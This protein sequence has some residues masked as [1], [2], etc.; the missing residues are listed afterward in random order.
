MTKILTTTLV[1]LL[2]TS[3][4]LSSSGWAMDPTMPDTKTPIKHVII[5]FQENISYDHYFGVYPNAPGFTAKSGT[6]TSDNYVAHPG[7]LTA[8]GNP[9][10]FPAFLLS[11]SVTCDMDHDYLPEQ[12]AYDGGLADKFVQFTSDSGAGCNPNGSTVMGYYDGQNATAQ[13]NI[14][15]N[16]AMSDSSFDT[17]FGPSTPGAVDLISGQTFGASEDAVAGGAAISDDD[18]LYDDCH[19]ASETWLSMSGKNIGDVLNEKG[20]TWGWF[21]GGFAP[22]TPYNP[23]T[24]AP[25][26]CNV[27]TATILT[28]S[29]TAYSAHHEPFEYYNST[30]NP[31]HLPPSTLAEIGYTDQANHQYD[32]SDFWAAISGAG[33]SQ[34]PQVSFIKAPKGDDGHASYSDPVDEGH[35]LANLT[36]TI[37]NSPYWSNTAV[38]VLWDDSDGWYDHVYPPIVN[39]SNDPVNDYAPTC[40]S[41]NTHDLGLGDA[42]DRCGYGARLPFLVISPYAKS[43]YISHTV[44]DQTSPLKFIEDNWNTGGVPDTFGQRSYDT[45][46]GSVDDMFDFTHGGNTSKVCLSV[47]DAYPHGGAGLTAGD[48]GTVVA[49]DSA[50]LC[51]TTNSYN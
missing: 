36:N 15:Q 39:H 6:P 35:F 49:P 16:F 37:E 27:K 43:D 30:A 40:G 18:P 3:L 8:S 46:A 23:A 11:N 33:G 17:E 38:F 29:Q 13:W 22:S 45:I 28:G 51:P 10:L 31:H 21:E 41:K 50:G 4:F 5:I 42:N 9:N 44:V 12:E 32:L 25:A 34:L 19:S 7:L 48:V 26:V 20:M 14:A 24:G 1:G 47:G 2:I